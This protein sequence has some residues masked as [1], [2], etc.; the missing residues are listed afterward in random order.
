MKKCKGNKNRKKFR[1]VQN[2]NTA[3]IAKNGKMQSLRNLQRRQSSQRLQ[4]MQ[5]M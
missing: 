2:K 1:V 5:R 4:S 3:G